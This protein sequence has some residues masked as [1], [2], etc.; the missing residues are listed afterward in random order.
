MLIM[1]IKLCFP[2]DS[3]FIGVS[4]HVLHPFVRL[5][6]GPTKFQVGVDFSQILA[7]GWNSCWGLSIA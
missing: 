7:G 5:V 4:I 3:R 2:N 1:L 6:L